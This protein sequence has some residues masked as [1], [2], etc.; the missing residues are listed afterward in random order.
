MI[1]QLLI[2]KAL[3]TAIEILIAALIAIACLPMISKVE[4][5]IQKQREL[6]HKLESNRHKPHTFS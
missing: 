3:I 2:Q 6:K 5:Q 1:T 4:E